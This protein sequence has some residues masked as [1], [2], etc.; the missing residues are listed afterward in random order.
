L[1]IHH[2]RWDDD[3]YIRATNII[4]PTNAN[5]S[6]IDSSLKQVAARSIH[7]GQVNLEKLEHEIGILIRAYDS[8]IIISSIL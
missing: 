5:S 3:G 7:N 8:A 4:T 6:V 2:F 1:L